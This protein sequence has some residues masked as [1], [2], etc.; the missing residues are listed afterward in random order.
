MLTSYEYDLDSYSQIV[1]KIPK[2]SNY[3]FKT[4]GISNHID[5]LNIPSITNQ[6]SLLNNT[7][8]DNKTN[9]TTVSYYSVN[10]KKTTKMLYQKFY[11]TL[12]SDKVV[13]AD[14]CKLS[15]Q[16]HK[17]EQPL[18]LFATEGT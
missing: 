3:T 4:T 9:Q 15:F 10:N 2:D 8:F 16:I 17:K 7:T 11:F 13:V 5:M 12:V 14:D 1:D 18:V 6:I